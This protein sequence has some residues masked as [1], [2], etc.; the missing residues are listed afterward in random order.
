MKADWRDYL[1][2]GLCITLLT[3]ISIGIVA[4]LRIATGP[5][6]AE[7][8]VAF[9]IALVLILYGL[10]SAGLLRLMLAIRP[11]PLGEHSM[12]SPAWT[13]WKLLTVLYRMGQGSLAWCTPFFMRPT[14]AALFGARIGADVA[15]GGGID[16]PYLTD[17]RSGVV[18]GNACLVSANVISQGKLLCLP[19][20]IREGATVGANAVVMPGADIGRGAVLMSGAHLMPNT[21]I[22]DGEVWRGN[23]ARKWP[24]AVAPVQKKKAGAE[25]PAQFVQDPGGDPL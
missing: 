1:L 22:P 8:R 14:L 20:V 11:M 24:Q 21:R 9:D 25:A 5:I 12:D 2:S 13:Y 23:P 3:V 6:L 15:I 10:A 4:S 18:L 16:D 19:V 17:I 7:Y